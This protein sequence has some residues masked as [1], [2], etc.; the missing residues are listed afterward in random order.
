MKT[1]PKN[2]YNFKL[3]NLVVILSPL[4]L[5][6]YKFWQILTKLKIH[7]SISK[8]ENYECKCVKKIVCNKCGRKL[9]GNKVLTT[10]K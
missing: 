8:F 3:R 5:I 4:L 6:N 7:Q 10:P 9:R 1:M 2:I